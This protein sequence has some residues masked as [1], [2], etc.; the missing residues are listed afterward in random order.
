[1]C[2]APCAKRG[3]LRNPMFLP[4]LLSL[5]LVGVFAIASLLCR[6]TGVAEDFQGSTHQLPYDEAPVRYSEGIPTDPVAVLRKQLA[7]GELKLEWDETH[8]YLPALLRALKVPVESQMLVFSKTSLQRRLIT[9]KTPRALYFNDDVY[10]GYIPGAPVLEISAADPKLG[11]VFYTLEQEKVRKPKIQRDSDCLRCHGSSRSLGVPGHIVRSIG[12]DETGEMDSTSESDQ[13]THCTPLSE[14][15]AG[16]YVTGKH[17]SQPHRG[18]LVGSAAFR[19]HESELNFAGNLVALDQYF[20]TKPYPRPTSDIVALMVLEH[21]AHM[22]NYITRLNFEAQQMIATYGHIRYLKNQVNAFLRYLL[23]V[24]E[25][26]LTEPVSGDPAYVDAFSALGPKDSKGRSLR[27]LDLHYRMF[28]YPCSYLIYSEAFD[29][30]PEQMHAHLLERLWKILTGE[31]QDPQ[32][33]KLGMEERR[34]ILEILRETKPGLPDYWRGPIVTQQAA[35]TAAAQ[36][37]ISQGR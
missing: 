1:M 10:L 18:N 27:Q 13:V 28:K 29:N 12:T 31:D 24:E 30:L 22:H 33:A 16:W 9:P 21:Q 25:A 8:G 35:T 17:G 3:Y 20:D 34:A 37:P 6:M 23:F 19:R 15:W 2:I 32:F 14:R 36:G 5:R 7:D 4:A 26:P 11:G